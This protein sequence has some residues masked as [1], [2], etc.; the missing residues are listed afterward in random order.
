MSGYELS[1]FL[2]RSDDYM[3]VRYRQQIALNS[4]YTDIYGSS[5]IIDDNY[6][7]VITD[8]IYPSVMVTDNK[9]A[10]EYLIINKP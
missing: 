6:L 8:S 7:L 10:D 5:V 4:A 3:K 2:Y 9:I 1:M